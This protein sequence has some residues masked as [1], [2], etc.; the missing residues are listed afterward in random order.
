MG[1]FGL[2]GCFDGLQVLTRRLEW[3]LMEVQ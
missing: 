1:L 3:R 2:S